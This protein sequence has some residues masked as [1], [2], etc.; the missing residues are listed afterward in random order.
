[1]S[2]F[3]WKFLSV[4]LS[5]QGLF[6]VIITNC[7]LIL[8]LAT[9]PAIAQNRQDCWVSS[10]ATQEK[11]NLRLLAFKGNKEAASRYQ[12]LLKQH[13]QELKTCRSQTWPQTQGIPV[14][15]SREQLIKLWIELSTKAITKFI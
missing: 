7:L 14:I 10:K 9:K 1:M 15:S 13:T 2:D 5:W 4:V 6:T 3:N 8:N 12:K 11:E